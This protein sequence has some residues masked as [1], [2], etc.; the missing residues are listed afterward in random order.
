MLRCVADNGC[1]RLPS[2]EGDLNPEEL[3]D[4]A[5]ESKDCISGRKVGCI[6]FVEMVNL[7]PDGVNLQALLVIGG[8]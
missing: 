5:S 1:R 2:T 7:P 6:N 4:S 3:D 8:S